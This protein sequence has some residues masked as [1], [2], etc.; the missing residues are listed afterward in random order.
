MTSQQPLIVSRGDRLF[1]PEA[2]RPAAVPFEAVD[3]GPAAASVAEIFDR[4]SVHGSSMCLVGRPGS[5]KSYAAKLIS[6]ALLA[7]GGQV[8]VLDR[9][10]GGWPRGVGEYARLGEAIPGLL[11]GVSSRAVRVGVDPVVADPMRIFSG[12]ARREHTL[13][14][15]A[16]MLD[17]DL[18]MRPGA[19]TSPRGWALCAAVDEILGGPWPS[20]A[21]LT[22]A[23]SAIAADMSVA[24]ER[25]LAAASLVDQFDALAR[26]TLLGQAL[27]GDGEL[28]DL[29]GADYVVF[30]A[31][32]LVLP[33]RYEMAPHL[34]RRLGP[35]KRIGEALLYLL[36]AI[37]SEAAGADVDRVGLWVLDEAS[38][39]VASPAVRALAEG[40]L[41]RSRSHRTPVLVVAQDAADVEGLADYIRYW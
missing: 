26:H 41:R 17:V 22:G 29:S 19:P 1:G 2:S 31:G 18:G 8:F 16:V 4:V 3:V 39:V 6:I 35:E 11:A 28:L 10:A 14:M 33:Q 15:C 13:G 20:M 23:F 36:A 34:R 7:R 21:R 40:L 37:A 32:H 5:G 25:R 27:F 30:E 9:A 38:P 24:A 12:D